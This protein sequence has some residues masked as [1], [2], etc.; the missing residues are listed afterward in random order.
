MCISSFRPLGAI[1][2]ETERDGGALDGLRVFFFPAVV[3]LSPTVHR[4]CLF[5]YHMWLKNNIL[6]ATEN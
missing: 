4:K 6:S 2:G 3:V 5:L 1:Q